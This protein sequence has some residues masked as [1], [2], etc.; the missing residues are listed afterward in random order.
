MPHPNMQN[1]PSVGIVAARLMEL[2]PEPERWRLIAKSWY[3]KGLAAT[4]GTGK[5]H[6]LLG[7]LSREKDGV[8]EELRGVY[9]FIKGYVYN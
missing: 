7:C 1:A 5:L 8:D 4:P 6:H 3:A 9:H 2:E